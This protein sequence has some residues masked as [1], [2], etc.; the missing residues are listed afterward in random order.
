M[1]KQKNKLPDEWF[2]NDQLIWLDGAFPSDCLKRDVKKALDALGIKWTI[3]FDETAG[4]TK[5]IST[6][7]RWPSPAIKD[8]WTT[9]YNTI[10][11]NNHIH[12][13][14]LMQM[15]KNLESTNMSEHSEQILDLLKSMNKTNIEMAVRMIS[16]SILEDK[17]ISWLLINKNISNVKQL[18][19][20]N[21]IKLGQW[22]THKTKWEFKG[23]IDQLVERLRVPES[24]RREFILDYYDVT[25]K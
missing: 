4:I 6:V 8:R 18:L 20:N 12:P 17:W 21:N 15:I 11:K 3:R 2:D 13:K 23:G 1:G 9:F 5:I 14:D 7:H 16:N 25:K 22:C 10:G 19:K 24:Y